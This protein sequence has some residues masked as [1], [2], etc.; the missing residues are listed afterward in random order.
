MKLPMPRT[1]LMFPALLVA[2][3][4]QAGRQWARRNAAWRP[5]RYTRMNTH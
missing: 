3:T 1:W 4:A 2:M 5:R